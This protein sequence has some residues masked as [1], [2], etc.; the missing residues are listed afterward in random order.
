MKGYKLFVEEMNKLSVE[1]GNRIIKKIFGFE[2]VI[3]YSLVEEDSDIVFRVYDGK[4]YNKIHRV[5][6]GINAKL[7][8]K[9]TADACGVEV[10]AGPSEAT[11]M[12]NIAV[13]LMALGEI[14]DLR[15]AREIIKASDEPDV[16]TPENT[17]MWDEVYEKFYK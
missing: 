1:E 4:K 3:V 16:Y 6:G 5:G 10:V 8:C 2:R 9:F 11:A 15:E 7:L 12:G 13:Q 17:K 14:K